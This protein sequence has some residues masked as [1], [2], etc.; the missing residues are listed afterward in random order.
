MA[1][2]LR[3]ITKHL[4]HGLLKI[5]TRILVFKVDIYGFLCRFLPLPMRDYFLNHFGRLGHGSKMITGYDQLNPSYAKY[6]TQAE[7]RAFLAD[8]GFTNIEIYH[9]HGYSWTVKG[10]KP[11][12]DQSM[13]YW[14]AIKPFISPLAEDHT[15]HVAISIAGSANEAPNLLS[16]LRL[17]LLYSF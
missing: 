8:Q 10:T 14:S 6:C 12:D 5:L 17:Q 7:A 2:R 13:T 11:K 15:M 1:K 9:R 16:R 3:R 4:S